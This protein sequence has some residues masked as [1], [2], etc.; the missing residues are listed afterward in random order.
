MLRRVTRGDVPVAAEAAKEGASAAADCSVGGPRRVFLVCGLECSGT[1][2]SK[3]LP[4]SAGGF[5]VPNHGHAEV[6]RLSFQR[7]VAGVAPPL[8]VESDHLAGSGQ[9]QPGSLAD[10]TDDVSM[11]V[12]QAASLRP[13]LNF[14]RWTSCAVSVPDV[15]QLVCDHEQCY[16]SPDRISAG[17]KSAVAFDCG[18]D[19]RNRGV[20]WKQH[21][22]EIARVDLE[23]TGDLKDG[24][25][26]RRTVVAAG[27]RSRVAQSA[28]LPTLAFRAPTSRFARQC[29]ARKWTELLDKMYIWAYK[30]AT[31]AQIGR[32][33]PR[34]RG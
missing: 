29:T 12:V 11:V 23:S 10:D 28:L 6:A 30:R 15:T 31:F 18:S 24:A 9:D 5:G 27:P 3:L 4:G 21:L 26:G 32:K 20:T 17:S 34:T 7:S 16:T 14:M 2:G 19:G 13:A 33:R 8:R 25:G 22:E 1:R